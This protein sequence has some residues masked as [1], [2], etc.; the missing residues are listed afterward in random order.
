MGRRELARAMV[1]WERPIQV[2]LGVAL[3]AIGAWDL[4]VN[5]PQ[6]LG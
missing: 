3:V 2:A 6:V 4:W 5:L 1:R